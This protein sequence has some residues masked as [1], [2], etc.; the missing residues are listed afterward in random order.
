M[1]I[2]EHKSTTCSPPSNTIK[3]TETFHTYLP[4]TVEENAKLIKQCPTKSCSQD[5]L[6]TWLLKKQLDI[7]VPIITDIVNQ[8]LSPGTFPMSF[9][10]ADITP[11]L[12]KSTLDPEILK[13]YRTVS[14][15]S[16][17]SKVVERVVTKHNLTQF[18]LH[19]PFQ[20]AYRKNHSTETVLLRVQNDVRTTLDKNEAVVLVLL[21]LSA[22]FD[23]VDHNMLLGRLSEFGISGTVWN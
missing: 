12:K 3:H 6:P 18:N 20:S 14:N 21:D 7:F 10:T 15:L 22:A 17:L 2:L 9:R 16:F 13:N 1:G 8:S 5:P 19:E 4:V 23:T 11:L